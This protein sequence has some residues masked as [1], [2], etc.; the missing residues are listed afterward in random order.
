MYLYEKITTFESSYGFSTE[1]VNIA[2]NGYYTQWMDKSLRRKI[3][4]EDANLTG[5]NAVHMGV[6][7]E[8]THR[9]VKSF[10]IERYVLFVSDWKWKDDIHFNYV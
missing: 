5:L 9:P 4:Q 6:E 10:G 2:L 1:Q 7:L 3:G 8:A